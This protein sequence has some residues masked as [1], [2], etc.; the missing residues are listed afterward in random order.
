[1]SSQ[2]E[3]ASFSV[4]YPEK[5]R[6]GDFCTGEVLPDEKI[7]IIALSDG[8]G[9]SPCDWKASKLSVT[10]FL[11]HFKTN[12]LSS[13]IPQ[14][15]REAINEANRTLLWEEGSCK[16]MKS[17]FSLLVWEYEKRITHRVNIGDSRI[18]QWSEKSLTQLSED[19]TQAVILRK[20]DGKPIVLSG[21]VV[22]AEGVTNVLG[23]HGLSFEV[24]TKKAEEPEGFVLASDGFYNCMPGFLK[25]MEDILDGLDLQDSMTSIA[26]TYSDF[27]KDDM[28]GIVIRKRPDPGNS[29]QILA[30]LLSEDPGETATLSQLEI[31]E[32]LIS[33]IPELLQQKENDKVQKLLKYC[34]THRIDLGRKNWSKFISLLTEY[35]NPDRVIYRDLLFKMRRSKL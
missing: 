28:T 26:Q 3:I 7:A 1:M 14:R 31:S 34:E 15:I 24:V 9:G 2:V 8:V 23:H 22:V 4:K 16:G 19:E 25:D 11:E 10:Q 12:N 29:S 6:N 18:F 35:D 5:T 17:T 33:A 32:V 27:Q 20:K 13:D 21:S 30:R